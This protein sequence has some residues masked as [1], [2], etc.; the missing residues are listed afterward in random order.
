MM[1]YHDNLEVTEAEPLVNYILS[2]KVNKIIKKSNKGDFMEY[3]I[4]IL[5]SRSKIEITNESG[6]F[7]AQKPKIII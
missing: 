5:K 2:T 1:K 4:N 7:M 3:V 6:L